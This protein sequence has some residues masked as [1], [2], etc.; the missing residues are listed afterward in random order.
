MMSGNDVLV[1]D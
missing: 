1:I